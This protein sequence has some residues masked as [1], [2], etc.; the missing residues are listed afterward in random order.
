[1]R[2]LVDAQLPPG[3]CAGLAVRGHDAVHVASVLS[4]ETPDSLIAAFAVREGRILLTKDDDFQARHG[5]AGLVVVWLRIG[6]STNRALADWLE[7]RWDAVEAALAEGERL[8][9]VR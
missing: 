8:I 7:T 2:F 3:L 4:G 5:S 6:N 1:M 9:E